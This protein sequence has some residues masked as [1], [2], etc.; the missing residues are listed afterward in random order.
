VAD[1]PATNRPPVGAVVFDLGG[2]VLNSPLPAIAA[3]ETEQGLPHRFIARLV[4]EGGHDGPWARLERGE[5]DATRFADA[6]ARQGADAGHPFDAAELLGR[7]ERAATPRQ[8]ML[9]ALGRLRGAGLRVA[10]LTNAWDM[11]DRTE[12]MDQLRPLFDLFVESFRVGMRKPERRIYELVCRELETAPDA[13]V[14]LDDLGSNLK[15]AREL[16][17]RTIK[18]A[19]PAVALNDLS[20][21][22]GASSSGIGAGS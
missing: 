18:V 21:L 14:F 7:I 17:M 8:A 1:P 6:F 11:P 16:G 5:L 19:D 15:P 2:V 12:R 4:V 3:Y 20:R 13:V 9:D 22:I 10:A